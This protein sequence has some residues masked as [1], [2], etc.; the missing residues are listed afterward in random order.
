VVLASDASHFYEN[1]MSNRPFTVGY[2]LGE[3]VDSYRMLERLAS[4]LDHII[5]G[6]D[7]EVMRR[8][9]PLSGALSGPRSRCM[10]RRG[11][12][13]SAAHEGVG[14]AT[15]GVYEDRFGLEVRVDRLLA[16]LAA[17]TAA[18]VATEGCH[19][20]DSSV[21]IDPYGPGFDTLR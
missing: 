1:M 15:H 12:R 17:E 7:P 13:A 16:V 4:S 8:Y 10:C 3:M 6:H 9:A 5:P 20:T 2:H 19:E 14:D 11:R 18:L 21:A